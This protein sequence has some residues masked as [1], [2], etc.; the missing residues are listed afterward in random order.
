MNTRKRLLVLPKVSNIDEIAEA[1]PDYALTK[2][3]FKN[4]EF[5]FSGNQASLLIDQ[6]DIREFSFVWLLSYWSSRDL[7][8]ATQLYLEHEGIRHTAVETG[9]SKLTDQM[10]F[11]LANI[12]T[13][14]TYFSPT[15]DL[16]TLV[17]GIESVCGYPVITKDT[18]GFRGNGSSLVNNREEL[19]TAINEIRSSRSF[20]FQRFIPNDY[21]WGI[22]VVNGKVMSG[23]KS[24]GCEAE[25]RNNACNGAKEFFF[26]VEEI[27]V[28]VKDM[29]LKACQA[30]KLDWARAD[31]LIEKGSEKPYLLEVNRYPGITLGSTEVTAAQAFLR[32]FLQ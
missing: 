2:G 7:A 27:P 32:P 8:Y 14:E 22:L 19:F 30:L 16:D 18:K 31:I 28:A 3:H 24:Y 6:T 12:T 1:F 5:K 17:K 4:L 21:D 26:P 11:S 23:E 20:F 15:T 13:P 9:T 29:A 25:F 10:A